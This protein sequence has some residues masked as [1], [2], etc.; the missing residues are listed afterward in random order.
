MSKARL[1]V[2]EKKQNPR[3]IEISGGLITIGRAPDN[4]VSLMSDS[5]VS[6]YHAQ[7]ELRGENFYLS[8][9]NSSNGTTLNDEPVKSEKK[10]QPNDQISFGGESFLEIQFLN[11]DAQS[12]LKQEKIEPAF[13]EPS[14]TESIAQEAKTESQ[15]PKTE[16]L[17]SQFPVMLTVA[18][19]LAGLA[20]IS[21]GI[22]GAILWAGNG[23]G[24]QAEATII[25]PESGATIAEPTEIKI[26]LKNSKCVDRAIYFVDGEEVGTAELEPYSIV[27]EPKSLQ[28]L[29][30]DNS[31]VLTVSLVDQNGA[32]HL[33]K[34]EILIA[35]EESDNSKSARSEKKSDSN[36]NQ[37][38]VDSSEQNIQNVSL[39]EVKIMSERLVKQLSRENFPRKFNQQFL[40][41]VAAKTNEYRAAGFSKRAAVYRDQINVA[42]VGE[43]GLDPP[44]GYVLAMSR[45]KF[46]LKKSVASQSEE[47]LW[48]LNGDFAA[49]NGYN[50]QCGQETL[51]DSAQNCA[52]RVAAIYTKALIVNLFQGDA[53]FG[54]ACFGLSPAE[55]GQFQ[56]ALPPDRSDFW[57]AIKDLKQRQNLVN[58]FAAGIVA[59]NPQKFGLNAD[60]PIS[61]LYPK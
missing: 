52:A 32:Q 54:V 2:A 38:T 33:Q 58:F 4:V 23:S 3:E 31:H 7:I 56:L 11:L 12:S 1:I 50:G 18:A 13:A 57:N 42:F 34:D 30:D 55:A 37:T 19:V 20:I 45:S 39:T 9:L 10:L 6:R 41:Q 28:K 43:Q 16:N 48:Q 59:D 49:S 35:F 25:D 14:S 22:V 17:K 8:D 51:S 26:N 47:G 21:V 53:V 44:L 24:C 46:D 60:Q 61:N 36:N 5:N 40:A 15:K 27:L 29:I